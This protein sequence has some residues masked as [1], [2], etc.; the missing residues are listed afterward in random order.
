MTLFAI[1]AA[2]CVALYIGVRMVSNSSTQSDGALG[3][4]CLLI[5]GGLLGVV[6]VVVR[7]LADLLF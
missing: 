4:G 5:V 3:A 2:C 6:A 1:L 7:V